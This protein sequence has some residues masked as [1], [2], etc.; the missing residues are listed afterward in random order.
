VAIESGDALG[1][2]VTI[3]NPALDTDGAIARALVARLVS[4]LN[5]RHLRSG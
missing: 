1:L 3:F 5:D 4:A 2:E